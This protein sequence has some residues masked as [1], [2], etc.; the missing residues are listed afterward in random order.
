L[1]ETPLIS[2]VDDDDW[3]RGA[4]EALVRS[5]GLATCTFTSAEAFLESSVVTETR[6]LVLDVQL[7][8]MSG[9]ELQHHLS[10]LGFDVPII[11]ITGYPDETVKARALNAG[12]ICFLYKPVDLQGRRLVDCLY[13]A[14]DGG[15][16][17][18][19]VT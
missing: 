17:P 19:P 6:C 4:I 7:P 3:I 8:N 13:A 14:L 1:T 12:A 18:A 16:G 9:I 10:H 11:F 5:L 2:I 15:K